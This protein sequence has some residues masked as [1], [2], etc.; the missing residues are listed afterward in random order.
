MSAAPIRIILVDDHKLA[1]ESWRML[2]SHDGR[3]LVV[4]E[5]DN[6]IEAIADAPT[7]NADVILVDINMYPIN[8]FEVTRKILEANPSLKII[9]ISVNNHPFYA[10]RMLE[11]G[12]RGFVTKGS[13]FEEII[14]A[15]IEVYNGEQYV[16]N[17]IKNMIP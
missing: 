2:L 1:R 14:H 13:P 5:Y 6:G 7:H 11:L 9:G 16:C 8:G 15:I 4:K 3:F 17:E 10:D 12:A